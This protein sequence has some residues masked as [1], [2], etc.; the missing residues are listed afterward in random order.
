MSAR[1][2]VLGRRS[3]GPE[4]LLSTTIPKAVVMPRIRARF[5]AG[6]CLLFATACSS[7]DSPTVPVER[8]LT[9]VE[10]TPSPVTINPG[11]LVQL[12]VVAKDDAGRVMAGVRPIFTTSSVDVASVDFV[13]RVLGLRPGTAIHCQDERRGRHR[14]GPDPRHGACAAR[15]RQEAWRD[16][17]DAPSA[18]HAR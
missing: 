3:P 7:S 17:L 16:V 13:G 8:R 12:V 2:P 10:V 14:H 5:T 1:H 15:A 11:E 6:L 18:F 9:T 4:W